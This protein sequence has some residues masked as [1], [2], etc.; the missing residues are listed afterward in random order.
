[1]RVALAAL[2]TAPA[3]L[4]NIARG[5]QPAYYAGAIAP[6]ARVRDEAAREATHF[7]SFR[8]SSTWG[9]ATRRLFFAYPELANPASLTG[10]QTAFVAGYLTHLAADEVFVA[11]LGQHAVQ[12]DGSAIGGLSW[13]IEAGSPQPP[14][15]LAAAFQFL[16]AFR[17]DGLTTIADS[18]LLERKASGVST[19][20]PALPLGELRRVIA[21]LN[22]LEVSSVES[23]CEAEARAAIGRRL[24]GPDVAVEFLAA[25][26]A[27]AVRRL[28]AFAAGTA[29]DYDAS[30]LRDST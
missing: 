9:T 6:D 21:A 3:G 4:R 17:A 29:A 16:A 20:D 28:R 27:E 26:E 30:H 25:A 23:A 18:G 5:F 2:E 14:Y 7:Y 22:G 13:A 12:G 24:F 19:I 11:R 15:G 1:M 10:C 8:D